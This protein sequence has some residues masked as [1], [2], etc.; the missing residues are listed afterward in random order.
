MT[1]LRQDGIWDAEPETDEEAEYGR[2]TRIMS[3]AEAREQDALRARWTSAQPS[4]VDWDYDDEE[5]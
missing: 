3:L 1:T 4:S 2:L 5:N